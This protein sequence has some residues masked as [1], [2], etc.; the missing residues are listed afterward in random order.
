MAWVLRRISL[1]LFVLILVTLWP[2]RVAAS[3]V[4]YS[5]LL[6]TN[7]IGVGSRPSGPGVEIEAAD[8]FVLTSPA[9]ITGISFIG[10]V[11]SLSAVNLAALNVEFYR[12]FPLDSNTARTPAVTTRGLRE[13]EMDSIGEFIAR[14]LGSPEDDRVARS[15]RAEVQTMCRAFPLYPELTHAR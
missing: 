6:V 7:Q 15:V 9:S 1:G 10:L 11:P 5:N 3:S 12:I 13:S 4:L 2:S 8:D 14:V